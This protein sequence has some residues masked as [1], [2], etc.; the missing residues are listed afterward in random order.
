ML[1]T[2]RSGFEPR[3][4]R[5]L[6]YL[7]SSKVEQSADNAQTMDRYHLEVPQTIA[8]RVNGI[9]LSCIREGCEVRV[10]A[11]PPKQHGVKTLTVKLRLLSDWNLVRIQGAGPNSCY[12]RLSVRT[13]A[14]QAGKT[15]STPVRSSRTIHLSST[16]RT[17]R[18]S[19]RKRECKSRQVFHANGVASVV[20]ARLSVKQ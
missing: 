3:T 20:E 9:P 5:Q 16:R 10:L 17:P 18:L 1:S 19:P 13:L 14:F 11:R 4:D 2:S 7:H 15:G 8:L 12:V 6:Q